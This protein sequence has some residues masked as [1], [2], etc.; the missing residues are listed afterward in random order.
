MGKVK[1]VLIAQNVKR[2]RSVL[3]GGSQCQQ[4]AK[5]SEVQLVVRKHVIKKVVSW[6][7]EGAPFLM[8]PPPA[9]SFLRQ[10]VVHQEQ[11]LD[12]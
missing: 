4:S 9:A 12:C 3:F 1:L 8:R 10:I 2:P 11:N 6:M 5:V 7:L